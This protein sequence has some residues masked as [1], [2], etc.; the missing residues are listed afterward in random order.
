[1]LKESAK[2]FDSLPL[3]W[4]CSQDGNILQETVIVC[5][6]VCDWL[7]QCD[8][9]AAMISPQTSLINGGALLWGL[10]LKNN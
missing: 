8:K 2:E 5:V 3:C 4:D 7:K 9:Y 1:M 10:T 6:C